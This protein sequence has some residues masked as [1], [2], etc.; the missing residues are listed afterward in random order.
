LF[1][2]RSWYRWTGVGQEARFKGNAKNP[3]Y[4]PKYLYWSILEANKVVQSVLPDLTIENYMPH[5]ALNITERHVKFRD[6]FLAQ[7][8]DIAKKEDTL[9]IND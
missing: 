7:Q 5:A 1:L 8:K 4:C 9:L 2:D 3:D 6:N